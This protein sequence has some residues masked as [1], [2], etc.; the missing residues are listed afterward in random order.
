MDE[1]ENSISDSKIMQMVKFL[2]DEWLNY[3]VGEEDK[4]DNNPKVKE[5][6]RKLISLNVML[7]NTQYNPR[8]PLYKKI[9]KISR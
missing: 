5:I 3:R 9:E 4:Y 1:V 7:P 2:D 8:H 6:Y